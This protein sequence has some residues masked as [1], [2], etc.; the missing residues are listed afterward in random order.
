[1]KFVQTPGGPLLSPTRSEGVLYLSRRRWVRLP[2]LRARP[3]PSEHQA[4][5]GRPGNTRPLRSAALSER[6]A[7]LALA[8][9]SR[10]W[11]VSCTSDPSHDDAVVMI[12]NRNVGAALQR[13]GI[14][15]S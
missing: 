3:R 1:M 8:I 4:C 13:S 12:D 10:R 11:N 6:V 2:G 7:A 5:D 15:K 14:A 9:P